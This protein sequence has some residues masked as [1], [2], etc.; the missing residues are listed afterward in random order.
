MHL[1][2]RMYPGMGFLLTAQPEHVQEVIRI[3]E[4]AGNAS[5]EIGEITGTKKL[6]ITNNAESV[7]VWILL[8]TPLWVSVP[9]RADRLQRC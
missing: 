3:F 1:W 2:L 9:S 8:G 7:V 5:R 6:E 4:E